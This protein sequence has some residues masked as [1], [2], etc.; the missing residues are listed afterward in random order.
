MKVFNADLAIKFFYHELKIEIDGGLV[1][2]ILHLHPRV[3]WRVLLP[4][5]WQ[6]SIFYIHT[7][8]YI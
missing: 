1:L 7:C 3:F 6:T 4:I 2:C 5:T 8:I